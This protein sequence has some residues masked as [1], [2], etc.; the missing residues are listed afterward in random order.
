[1][2]CH[3]PADLRMH[4]SHCSHCSVPSRPVCILAGLPVLGKVSVTDG[5]RLSC[6]LCSHYPEVS[7]HYPGTSLSYPPP[8]SPPLLEW[9]TI[10]QDSWFIYL[11]HGWIWVLRNISI[12]WPPHCL[13]VSSR[14]CTC[15]LFVRSETPRAPHVLAIMR[16]CVKVST[17]VH[18]GHPLTTSICPPRRDQQWDGWTDELTQAAWTLWQ[19]WHSIHRQSCG[20]RR[21]KSLKT[22]G[23]TMN[24]DLKQM[25]VKDNWW[26]TTQGKWLQSSWQDCEENWGNWLSGK[27]CRHCQ[28]RIG[29]PLLPKCTTTAPALQALASYDPLKKWRF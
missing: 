7:S 28:E 17:R 27:N 26:R 8:S 11:K 29:T 12:L 25:E 16:E 23:N 9:G 15:R 20:R 1:M 2:P 21:G 13:G 10:L 4:C 22:V 6:S 19:K 3:W 5:A 24:L 14:C 18:S